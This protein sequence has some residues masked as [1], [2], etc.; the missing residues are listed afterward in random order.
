MQAGP[1]GAVVDPQ[2]L[3]HVGLGLGDDGDVAGQQGCRDDADEDQDDGSDGWHEVHSLS[4]LVVL[5]I[6][7]GHVI[8]KGRPVIFAQQHS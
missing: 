8:V 6:S 3:D 4:I 2:A 7:H 1:P 5:I